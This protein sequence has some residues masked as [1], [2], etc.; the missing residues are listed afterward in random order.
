MRFTWLDWSIVVIYIV[1]AFGV[2]IVA[3]GR[4]NKISDFLVAGRQL[5]YHLGVATLV[6][7]ELGLITM[8]YFAEQGFRF[9]LSA[10]IIGII[11][12]AAYYLV[13]RT[14][15]V[16]DRIRRLEI[17]TI[18]EY[19]QLRYSKGVRVLGAVLLTIAGVLSLGIFL[20]LGA[21]FLIHFLNIPETSLHITMTILVGVVVIYTMLGGMISVV[22]TDYVQFVILAIGM[23]ATTIFVLAQFGFVDFFSR[24]SSAYGP[25][26]LDPL[27]H[28]EYGWSFIAYWAVFAVSGC[29]LWQP[30]TQ[31]VFAAANPEVNRFI[32]KSTSMM[33]L[34]RAFFPI[35]W[36]IGAALYFGAAT[37][38]T[39][40]MPKFL[41]EILPVGML[42][43][44]TAG[45]FAAM[46]STD[47]GYILAWSSIITRDLIGSIWNVSTSD[48][49]RIRA[50]RITILAIG[51]LMLTVGIWY[52]LKETAF[53]YLLDVTTIY[54]AGGFPVLVCGLYWKR[55]TTAGAYAAFAFGA[56]L[57]LAFVVEDIVLQAQGTTSPGVIAQLLSPNLR[58]LMSFILGFV[59]MGVG[60]LVTANSQQPSQT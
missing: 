6:A 30:V 11:W 23:I 48:R 44:L 56:L 50:T 54:Y 17:M 12:A 45:M 39:A 15:F 33:F 53:R 7:T 38:A 43:L 36:G 58:G 10:F 16:V 25:T 49:D 14:G 1:V 51:A 59:G 55:A 19:F 41:A 21:I 46:M 29:I 42:G 4:V 35:I 37:D 31:R 5:R 32:F 8:M 13:G 18:T 40:G 57:P 34:G 26:G 28:P 22:L 2:G 60:S 27:T 24:V 20:K 9:G 3:R 52:Q 47:S